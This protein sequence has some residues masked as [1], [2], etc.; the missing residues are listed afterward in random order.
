ML[1]GGEVAGSQVWLVLQLRLP[2]FYADGYMLGGGEAAGSHVWLVSQLRL[3]IFYADG[4]LL[5]GGEVAGSHVW[6]VLQL[7]V[8]DA[9][10]QNKN[11]RR[12]ACDK[13]THVVAP[14]SR[15]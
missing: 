15:D 4:Y 14:C 6:L 10:T 3:P 1:G 7:S 5:G 13:M 2:I 8:A 9:F 11:T 12:V